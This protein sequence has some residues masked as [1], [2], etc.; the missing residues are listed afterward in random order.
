[1]IELQLNS[2]PRKTI[3]SFDGNVLEYFSLMSQ[4]G[5]ARFHVGHF[6]SIELTTD[7]KGKHWL[8]VQTEA[9]PLNSEVDDQALAK[10]KDLVAAVQKAMK[11]LAW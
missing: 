1:M 8:E 4:E 11:S 7:K 10:T 5:S 3:L 9:R 6:K 2:G